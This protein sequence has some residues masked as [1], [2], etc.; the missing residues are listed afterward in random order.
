MT[1]P[2][3][4]ADDVRALVERYIDLFNADDFD[5]AFDCYRMPFTWLFGS[6]AVTVTSR[7]EFL[8]MMT[9]TKA[10]LVARGLGRSRLLG[11]T[12]RMMEDHVALA[13]TAIMRMRADGSE[14][15]ELGGTYMVHHDGSKWRLVGQATHPVDAIVPAGEA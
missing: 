1:T 9:S 6:R 7:D 5:A 8:A 12:V 15:E 4:R 10:A 11:V 14:L 2:A 3:P 13:G